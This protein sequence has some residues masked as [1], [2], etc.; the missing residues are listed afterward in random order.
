MDDSWKEALDTRL[1]ELK[2]TRS[3][4]ADKIGVTRA[5][6]SHIFR[7]GE[8][9]SLVPEIEKAVGWHRSPDQAPH[10]LAEGTKGAPAPIDANLLREVFS[11]QAIELILYF[12]R[13]NAENK[14]RIL[15]RARVLCEEQDRSRS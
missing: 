1:R 7:R 14:S 10:R 8:Q 9:S 15:E 2:W 5:A 12:R 4:L 3:D 13:L 11:P 6:I